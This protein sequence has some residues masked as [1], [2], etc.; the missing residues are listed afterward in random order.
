MEYTNGKLQNK[1]TQNGIKSALYA[2][3]SRVRFEQLKDTC[4]AY[5]DESL[6]ALSHTQNLCEAFCDYSTVLDNPTVYLENDIISSEPNNQES[7][8]TFCANT[9]QFLT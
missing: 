9:I 8:C 3:C 5:V 6:L 7:D 4:I 2:L 1:Q